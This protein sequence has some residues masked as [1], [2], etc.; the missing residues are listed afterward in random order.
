[1]AD[2]QCQIHGRNACRCGLSAEPEDG[3]LPPS[4]ALYLTPSPQDLKVRWEVSCAR[5]MAV[6]EGYEGYLS[7]G[8]EPF[9]VTTQIGSGP[10]VWFRRQVAGR[11]PDASSTAAVWSH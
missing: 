10:T 6:G 3:S 5:F 11:K 4:A 1:M 2:R 9:A 7:D 8:W